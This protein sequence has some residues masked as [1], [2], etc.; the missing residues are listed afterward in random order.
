MAK[1]RILY[2]LLFA[3]S[4]AFALAYESK[5][6][7]ILL[8]GVTVLPVVTLILLILSGLLLKLEVLQETIFVSKRQTFGVGVRISNRFIIPVSPMIITCTFHDEDGNVISGRSLVLSASPLRQSEYVFR[9]NIRYRGEYVLG[10]EDAVIYDLLRIFKFRVRKK[11]TCTITVTPRRIQL[12]E[13][14]SICTDDYDSDITKI[15]FMDSSSFSSVRPYEDGDLLKRVHWKLSAKQDELV[16]K[17]PEQNLGSSALII[18]DL[19]SFSPV[20]E[21]DLRAADAAAETALA[22]TRKIIEDGRTAVNIFRPQDGEADV[23]SAARS[24]DHE[25]LV[26]VFAVL[27]ITERGAGAEALVPKAAEWLTGSEPLFIITPETDGELFASIVREVGDV[28]GEIRLYLTASQPDQ[29]LITEV[30]SAK[31]ASVYRIDPEDVAI[32]LRNSFSQTQR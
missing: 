19:H 10:V 20:E 29:K 1:Y 26:S 17:Q 16:V 5:L 31:N 4:M 30:Q 2:T 3:G 21:E 7:L 24:E 13:A 9:G 14:A 27:P 6:S 18:T 12:D 28:C 32:S 11:P 15:S 25:H 22:L 8:T 23:F